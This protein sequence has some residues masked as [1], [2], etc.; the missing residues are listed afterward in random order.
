M[1]TV[2][3]RLD[4]PG[5]TSASTGQG[6]RPGWVP[7]AAVWVLACEAMVLVA[8][9][10]AGLTSS[11]GPAYLA[12]PTPMEVL[13][14]RLNPVHSALLLLTG[15]L[16]CAALWRP[17]W[18]RRFAAG[19]TVAY[20]LVVVVTL[21]VGL[22]GP[23]DTPWRLGPTDHVLHAVLIVLGVALFPVLAARAPAERRAARR[24]QPDTPP[25]TPG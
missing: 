15:L 2:R 16:A 24:A 1:R 6:R 10:V 22:Y 21:L 12:G 17:V 19:Q 9:G 25:V 13:G 8:L 3:P 20:L 23:P 11:G 4:D 14:F 18:R 5:E 7:A